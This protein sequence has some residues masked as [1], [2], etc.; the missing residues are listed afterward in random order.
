[1][2][3]PTVVLRRAV[4]LALAATLLLAVPASAHPYIQGGEAPVDSLA[5]L[6]LDLG[7]GCAIDE[8]GHSHGEG[9]EEPTTEVALEVHEQMRIV[10]VPDVDGFDVDLETD[11]DGNVEVVVWT[12]TT[13]TEPAPQLPFD[14]VFSGEPGDELYLRVFQGC[15]ELS[16]R[17]VGTPDEPAD[18]PAVGLVLTEADPA[19]PPPPEEEP[20]EEPT[21]EPAEAPAAAEDQTEATDPEAD[22]SAEEAADQNEAGDEEAEETA[23]ATV[24][25]DTENS[26]LLWGIVALVVVALVLAVIL[27]MR[28][29][30][31][32]AVAPNAIEGDDVDGPTATT[33][34]GGVPGPAGELEATVVQDAADPED[35]TAV[36]HRNGAD[37]PTLSDADDTTWT[38]DPTRSDADDTTWTGDPDGPTSE[39]RR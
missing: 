29:R 9:P 24:P 31:V 30:P 6:V 37:D 32:A 17:W 28:R 10:D 18:E 34:S 38:G 25:D 16:S 33:A 20:V 21:D 1:M 23:P 27:A 14:A 22:D 7:H 39:D 15:D 5:E 12:A 13:S 2:T 3:R 19:S 8:G 11:D 35:A 26:P 36:D 4:V